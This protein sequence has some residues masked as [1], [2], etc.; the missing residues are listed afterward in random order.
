MAD[1][2]TGEHLRLADKNRTTE[3]WW[4]D[5]V[6]GETK[7]IDRRGECELT[8]YLYSIAEMHIEQTDY[9]KSQ[10]DIIVD[11]W[12]HKWYKFML[13]ILGVSNRHQ[14]VS[15]KKQAEVF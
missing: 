7:Q 5:T 6:N 2:Q 13:V 12:F 14:D 3:T 10:E 11:L 8:K 1:N 15:A 9:Y 4:N